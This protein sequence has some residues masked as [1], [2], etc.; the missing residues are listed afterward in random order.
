MAGYM[1]LGSQKVCPAIVSGGDEKV[2]NVDGADWLGEVNNQGVLVAP[3]KDINLVFDGVED[4][5]DNILENKFKGQSR[6]K[7]VCFPDLEKLSGYSCM[8]SSF[9]NCSNVSEVSFPKLKEIT[10]VGSFNGTFYGSKIATVNFPEL[11]KIGPN[12]GSICYLTFGNSSL[13]E[14]VYFPKLKYIYGGSAFSPF[15][16]CTNLKIVDFSSLEEI[17]QENEYESASMG[18][19][20]QGCTSLETVSFPKLTSINSDEGLYECFINCTSLK[21]VYFNSL[22]PSGLGEYTSQ[23]YDML[24]NCSGVTLHFLSSMES[25]MQSMSGYPNFGGTNTVILYDLPAME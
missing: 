23:F 15:R 20:F 9:Y 14:S 8:Y 3:T 6:V 5:S 2:Y 17:G 13:L 22:T 21:S 11:E 7:S 1:Y 25:V 12:Y 16:N 19:C 4:L 18:Y 24:Y 10:G